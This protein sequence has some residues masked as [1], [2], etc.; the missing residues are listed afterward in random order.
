M[1]VAYFYLLHTGETVEAGEEVLEALDVEAAEGGGQ[2]GHGHDGR[3]QLGE[4]VLG[5]GEGGEGLGV[6]ADGVGV[7]VVVVAEVQAAEE[8]VEDGVGGHR[9]EIPLEDVEDKHLPLLLERRGTRS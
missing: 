5:G 2:A 1:I 6:P 8:V 4:H 7:K 3:A 9:G